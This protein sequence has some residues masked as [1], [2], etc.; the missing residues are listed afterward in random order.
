MPRNIVSTVWVENTNKYFQKELFFK[1]SI[2]NEH[3]LLDL[4]YFWKHH[5]TNQGLFSSV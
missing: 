4:K 5:K 3:G 2:A 1:N